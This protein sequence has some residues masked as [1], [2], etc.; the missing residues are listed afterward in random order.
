MTLMQLLQ[1]FSSENLA[2]YK[3]QK[4]SK[5]T[6]AEPAAE[7]KKS[8]S[9]NKAPK[10][11]PPGFEIPGMDV[12]AAPASAQAKAVATPAAQSAVPVKPVTPSVK[13]VQSAPVNPVPSTVNQYSSAIPVVPPQASPV[14]G[15]TIV[16]DTNLYGDTTVL[17]DGLA[18]APLQAYL[19]R[20][21]SGEKIRIN[22]EVFRIGRAYDYVDYCIRDNSSVSG[23]HAKIIARGGSYFIEDTN[24]R[25][26]TYV[27]GEKI[28]SNT[29][30]PLQSGAKVR[31][32]NEDF[33]FVLM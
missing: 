3:A 1:N 31:L 10:A 2:I 33:E 4:N 23:A 9:K 26:H 25:N 30:V 19:I 18:A 6:A 14:F 5:G 24:S 32:S 21:K 7:P 13:P 16:L 28:P 8:K 29:E 12:P 27:N 20:A 11:A 22:G 17:D 15:E